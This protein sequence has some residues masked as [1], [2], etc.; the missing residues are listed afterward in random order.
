MVFFFFAVECLAE[1]VSVDFEW[2]V[3]WVGFGF[4]LFGGSGLFR[5]YGLV[6][7][8]VSKIHGLLIK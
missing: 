5:F 6:F 7:F 4:A 3:G 2:V 8:L 1:F